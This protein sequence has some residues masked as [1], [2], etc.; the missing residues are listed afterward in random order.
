MTAASRSR[1]EMNQLIIKMVHLLSWS[2][3]IL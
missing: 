2:V 1:L 3:P